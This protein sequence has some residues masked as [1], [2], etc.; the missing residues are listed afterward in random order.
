MPKLTQEQL[1]DAQD[2]FNLYDRDGDG[3]ITLAD[4]GT[5]LRCCGK[6]PT[7]AEVE[8]IKAEADPSG[9]GSFTFETLKT[10]LEK[11]T[12]KA[13]NEQDVKDCFRIFDKDGTGFVPVS[14][15]RHV[16]TTLGEKLSAAEVDDLLRDAEVDDNG[17]LNYATFVHMLM[18]SKN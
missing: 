15:L 18:P 14:E 17:N 2:A 6:N 5:L 4:L 1:S 12:F 3:K 13:D 7:N 9:T 8:N 11:Y 10:L 16:L